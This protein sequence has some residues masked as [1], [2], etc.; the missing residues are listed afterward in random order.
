[1]AIGICMPVTRAARGLG[2]LLI[3]AIFA[4]VLFLGAYA[5]LSSRLVPKAY[6]GYPNVPCVA[7]ETIVN[8]MQELVR[9]DAQRVR[10]M[11]V[12][13]GSFRVGPD[14]KQRGVKK[15]PYA[16]SED[17]VLSVLDRA[18]LPMSSA[19]VTYSNPESQGGFNFRR[20]EQGADPDIE[21]K[22]VPDLH[23]QLSYMC[24]SMLEAHEDALVD[25]LRDETFG[26]TPTNICAQLFQLCT[27]DPKTDL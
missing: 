10:D 18:C 7:C 24:D 11:M 19:F 22:Q 23:R 26:Q 3:G 12:N 2:A 13:S 1:M 4:A 16:F 15:V 17:H 8:E 27:V 25:I 14:G 6:A 9:A 20:L 5:Q 21:L